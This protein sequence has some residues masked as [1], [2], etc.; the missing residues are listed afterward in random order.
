MT[1]IKAAIS[2]KFFIIENNMMD[3][4]GIYEDGSYAQSSEWS[5]PSKV[6]VQITKTTTYIKLG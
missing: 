6:E 3:V 4:S 5:F 1:Q 2:H